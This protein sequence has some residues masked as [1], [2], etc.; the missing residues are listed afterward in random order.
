MDRDRFH[1]EFDRLIQERI[2]WMKRTYDRVLPV[3]ELLFNRFDKARYL[4]AG[5]DSSVYDSSVIMGDVEIGEHVWIGPFTLIEGSNAKVRIGDFV[6]IDTG[7]HIYTHDS[8]AYYLSG[9]VN[10]FEK[11][12][13]EIGSRSVIGSQSIINYGVKVGEGCLIAANSFVK[14]DVPDGTI[15]AGTPAKQIGTVHVDPETG[16]VELRYG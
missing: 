7:V 16:K 2:D 8:T 6:S 5:R 11:G 10:D 3:G 9:G 15:F 4:E 1:E 13:V 12:P 14:E